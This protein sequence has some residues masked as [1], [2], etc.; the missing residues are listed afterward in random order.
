MYGVP[1][2][3]G[4]LFRVSANS[5]RNNGVP[6]PTGG[7]GAGEGGGGGG[8]EGG[9]G[10]GGD[11]DGGGGDG[12]GGGRGDGDGGGG[13]GYNKVTSIVTLTLLY[14]PA[15]NLLFVSYISE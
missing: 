8:G 7:G 15:N 3:T 2:V 9:N 11:G 10:G 4:S 13:E 5:Y 12:D 1:S 14:N 6:I